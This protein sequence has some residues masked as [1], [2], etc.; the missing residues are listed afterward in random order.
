METSLFV[1][2]IVSVGGLELGPQRQHRYL[3]SWS[4]WY[5]ESNANFLFLLWRFPC[6]NVSI[7]KFLPLKLSKLKQIVVSHVNWSVWSYQK[8]SFAGWSEIIWKQCFKTTKTHLQTNKTNFVQN[9]LPED[10]NYITINQGD[11]ALFSC[12]R[13]MLTK[14]EIIC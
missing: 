6:L 5:T 13:L 4:N 14:E 3:H 7:S 8:I 1:K 12:I 10:S 11:N 9:P 2:V